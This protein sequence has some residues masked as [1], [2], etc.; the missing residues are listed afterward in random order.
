MCPKQLQEGGMK[1]WWRQHEE[2]NEQ[3]TSSVKGLWGYL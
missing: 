1:G 2:P 3:D